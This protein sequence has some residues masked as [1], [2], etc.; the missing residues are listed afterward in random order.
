[1]TQRAITDNRFV[2]GAQPT[3]ERHSREILLE[4]GFPG[5][6]YRRLRIREIS[7]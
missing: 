5:E 4:L 3:P 2:R 7:E 1:M 6:E